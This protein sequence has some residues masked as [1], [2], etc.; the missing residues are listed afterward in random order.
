MTRKKSA[1]EK[2]GLTPEQ[3]SIYQTLVQNNP[4][5]PTD[6]VR[7]TKLHRP[8]VYTAL[9]ELLKLD[10]VRI[11]PFGKNKKYAAESPEHL[12]KIFKS[13]EDDFNS[14]I[15]HL[16][17]TFANKDR[18]PIVTFAQGEKAMR[19]TFADVV[20]ELKKG[21]TYYRYS[22]GM[23]K[24]NEKYI[25]REF[26]RLRDQKQLERLV[27][28]DPLSARLMNKNLGKS[29]RAVPKEIDLF[30]TKIN[31]WIFGDKV[32]FVDY[33]SKSIITIQNK[34]IAQFQKAIFKLLYDRLG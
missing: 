12:E 1:L 26:R 5:S 31:Q 19:D 14:E 9:A 11:M 18:K 25:P 33:N 34:K 7:L 3:A 30:A 32:A 8:A 13:I 22:P 17:D 21:D 29:I 16:H 6:I 4:L 24:E 27:I 23:T 10:L 2:I 20:H 28:T 15:Y